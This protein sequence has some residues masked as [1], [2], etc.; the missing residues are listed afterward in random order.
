M[1]VINIFGKK[2]L[3]QDFQLSLQRKLEQSLENKTKKKILYDCLT[4]GDIIN[5]INNEG[6]LLCNDLT[7]K[8]QIKRE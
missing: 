6:L 4:Y 8:H 3:L 2:S 1:T 7:L 5:M